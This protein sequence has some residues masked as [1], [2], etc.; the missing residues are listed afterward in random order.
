MDLN[1]E[2]L[3]NIEFFIMCRNLIEGNH[4][5]GGCVVKQ[6]GFTTATLG[7]YLDFWFNCLPAST[8]ALCRPICAI[9]D[10]ACYVCNEDHELVKAKLNVPIDVV[11][12]TFRKCIERNKQANDNQTL[13]QTIS[14]LRE[15]IANQSINPADLIGWQ[16]YYMPAGISVLEQQKQ[17]TESPDL[18]PRPDNP[19]AQ[20]LQIE[21]IFGSDKTLFNLYHLDS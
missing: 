1:T 7:V 17:K 9:S 20:K 3:D 6:A 15:S 13:C 14:S 21:K 16:Q 11:V 5:L 8:D 2:F 19:I 12:E 4:N 10:K 18:T